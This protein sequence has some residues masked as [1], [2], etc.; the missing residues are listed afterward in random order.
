MATETRTIDDLHRIALPK[1]MCDAIDIK[2]GDTVEITLVD[3]HI[4]LKKWSDAE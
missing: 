1:K 4:I 2:I 3:E